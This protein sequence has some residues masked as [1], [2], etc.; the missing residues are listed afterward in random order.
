MITAYD[1][2]LLYCDGGPCDSVSCQH[3]LIIVQCMVQHHS[4]PAGPFGKEYIDLL[5][6]ELKHLSLGIYHSE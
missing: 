3:W 5:Y 2:K 1:D 4:L 6:A